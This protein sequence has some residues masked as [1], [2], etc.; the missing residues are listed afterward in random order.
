MAAS[1]ERFQA[2]QQRYN[3][4]RMTLTT[5][6]RTTLWNACRVSAEAFRKHEKEFAAVV[7]EL[8][9]GREMPGYPSGEHGIQVAERLEKQFKM[10]ADETEHLMDVLE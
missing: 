6:E 7:T 2:N 8:K 9:A 1:E 3:T 5:R 4:L 10:Q